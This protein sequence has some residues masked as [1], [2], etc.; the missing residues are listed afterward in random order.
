MKYLL[1]AAV[2]LS[3][4]IIPNACFAETA[5]ELEQLIKRN[6]TLTQIEDVDGVLATIHT[7]SSI[8]PIQASAL[9]QINSVYDL[10]Y[11]ILD[12]YFVGSEENYAYAR[13]KLKTSKVAGPKFRNNTL[14]VL[15]AFKQQEGVWKFWNQVNLKVTFE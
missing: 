12:Y 1:V 13:F 8:Y 11:E 5:V 2:I 9:N 15:A 7:E 10:E 14:E 3:G 4:L 6:V